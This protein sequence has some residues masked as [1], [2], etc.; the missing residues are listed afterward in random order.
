MPLAKTTQYQL[1]EGIHASGPSYDVTSKPDFSKTEL[2]ALNE[3]KPLL[4]KNVP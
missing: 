1:H 4:F 3:K 2:A